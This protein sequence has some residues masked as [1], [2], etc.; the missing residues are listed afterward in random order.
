MN[1]EFNEFVKNYFIHNKIEEFEQSLNF[2]AQ[3][4]TIA[5]KLS[6]ILKENIEQIIKDFYEHILNNEKAKKYFHSPS[7]IEG[8]MKTNRNYIP[9]LF[10]GPFDLE[11]YK[12]K[13]K[14]GYMHYIR[15][16]PNDIYLATLGNLSTSLNKIWKNKFTDIIELFEAQSITTDL[17]FIEAYFTI[18]TYYLFLEKKL[19]N[20][21]YK[22]KEI[23]NNI[24]DAYFVVNSDLKISDI[25]SRA[26]H[27][28]FEEDIAGKNFADV[29]NESQIKRGDILV[30]A[31]KQYFDNLF[32]VESIF[33][34]F[35]TCIQ[36]HNKTLKLSY[37]P[38]LDINKKPQKIIIC[39]ND[40]SEHI[41]N[42]KIIEDINAKNISLIKIIKHKADFENMLKYIATKNLTLL[43]CDDIKTGKII[44][45]EYKNL[46]ANYGLVNI[47]TLINNLEQELIEKEQGEKFNVK[48]FLSLS[49]CMISDLL[50]KYLEENYDIL[51]IAS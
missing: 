42:Q 18:N 35:P 9:Y 40:I 30:L 45:H 29:F 8:L 44:L 37:T 50:K 5:I 1:D 7:E 38:I 36:F 25:T 41:K 21:K 32:N 39:A 15:G 47:S 12:E 16:I 20:E 10:S 14:I 28:I 49:C 46:F 19:A 27:I 33:N 26:C 48:E 24:Q 31:I 13:I 6:E 23:L 51:G 2:D 4:K 43:D 11:Y 34:I 17:L 22:V 3:K